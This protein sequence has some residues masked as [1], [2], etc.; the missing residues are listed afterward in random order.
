MCP[1]GRPYSRS[2]CPVGPASHCTTRS[3]CMKAAA[4]FWTPTARPRPSPRLQE[5]TPSCFWAGSLSPQWDLSLKTVRNFLVFFSSINLHSFE[6]ELFKN[7]HVGFDFVFLSTASPPKVQPRYD[8]DLDASYAK[9]QTSLWT[10]SSTRTGDSVDWLMVLL[11]F[12]LSQ[13]TLDI[14]GRPQSR[15]WYIRNWCEK[16]F[17]VWCKSTSVQRFDLSWRRTAHP[18]G[19]FV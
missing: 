18:A 5:T 19:M 14:C 4:S 1:T 16:E 7:L 8:L 3:C 17:E 12:R 10:I 15:C 2:C 11:L 6:V 13:E 9:V